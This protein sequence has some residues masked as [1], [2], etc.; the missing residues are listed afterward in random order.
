[1]RIARKILHSILSSTLLLES[2]ARA[3]GKQRLDVGLIEFVPLVSYDN[4]QPDGLIFEYAHDILLSAN[5][6]LNYHLVSIARSLEQLRSNHLDLVLTLFKAPEREVYT[7]YS[8]QPLLWLN[9]GFCTITDIRK[10]S[11]SL[12]TRLVH[13]RGTVLPPALQTLV[14]VPVSGD[15]AQLRMLQM[16]LKGRVD[17]IYS[18]KPEVI[19]LAAYQ[20]KIAAPLT[21]Y[22]LKNSRMPVYLGFSKGL[23][24]T[25]VQKIEVA[26]QKKIQT[27]DFDAFLRRR[28]IEA[29]T[30]PPA[31]E[32]IAPSELP[33]R[34]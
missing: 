15:N 19:M 33:R 4:M 5:L 14:L 31:V 25:L 10:K 18:P 27:E 6:P 26:L 1:M 11:L 2:A 23:T 12:S 30:T 7:R 24:A 32:L 17:A 3:D 20:A 16:L 13:V 8:S 29:G 9:S 34:P 21:C 28:M 22:E